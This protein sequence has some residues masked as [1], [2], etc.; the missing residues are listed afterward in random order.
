MK[1]Y[2]Q[3]SKTFLNLLYEGIITTE[4]YNFYTLIVSSLQRKY[5][6]FTSGSR[7]IFAV[8]Q[9]FTHI[10]R[11]LY[12]Q[13]FYITSRLI[14]LIRILQVVPISSVS[15]YNSSG[16]NSYPTTAY[17]CNKIRGDLYPSAVII[18][19]KEVEL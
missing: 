17:H 10:E 14:F 19:I 2:T 11:N 15:V 4:C 5:F 16:F 8:K 7:Y 12:C 9:N 18:V 1:S 13:I 3:N 6:P